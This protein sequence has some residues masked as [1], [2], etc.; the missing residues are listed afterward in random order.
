MFNPFSVNRTI[1]SGLVD[2]VTEEEM[3]ARLVVGLCNLPPRVM[4]GVTSTGML[5]CAS[6]EDHTRRAEGFL[7]K[8]PTVFEDIKIIS[9]LEIGLTDRQLG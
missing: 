8:F 1:V 3:R 2:Y 4:R 7:K 6:N 9:C 5:L